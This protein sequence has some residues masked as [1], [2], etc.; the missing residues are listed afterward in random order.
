M[1]NLYK[2]VNK[3]KKRITYTRNTAQKHF[4]KHK[5][6]RN[7][8][9]KSRQLGFT[10]EEALDILDDTLFTR[11]FDGLLIAH[12]LEDAIKIFDKKIDFAWK[13]FNSELRKLWKVSADRANELKYDFGDNTFSSISVSNSGRSGTF[14][15]VHISEFAKLCN[16]YPA[17]AEEV[18]TGTIPAVPML[19]R[20]DIESTAEGEFGHFYDMFWKA[21]ERGEPTQPTEY[22]AHF[23][24]WTWDLDELA[25]L[26]EPIKDLPSEFKDYQKLHNLTDIQISY[27]YLKWISLNENWKKLQ[28]EYPT[29]PE[30]AFVSSGSKLFNADIVVLQNKYIKDGTQ[31]NNWTIYEDYKPNHRYG[32]GADVSHGKG[33]DGSTVVIIDF[34]P[35]IPK[36]VAE[37]YSNE[38]EPTTFAH[39]IKNGLVRFGTP[40][41]AVENND[42]GYTTLVTLKDIYPM[43]MIYKKEVENKEETRQTADLGWNTNG[44]TKPKMMF[45][46][47]EAL[48]EELIEIPSRVILKELRTYDENNLT[49]IKFDDEMSQ[50]WDRV[51]ALAIAWQM[52]D[53][54]KR[55]IVNNF[56][57]TKKTLR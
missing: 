10:T 55:K 44:A 2:I 40:L 34:T 20:V 33:K 18:I 21:W 42:R 46:L 54:V 48:E 47:N 49:Q 39:E 22:K 23:Y 7:L 12:T 36:V 30:E 25:L 57:K 50:H 3:S 41:I 8:I 14:N 5:W 56:N 37:Y 16:K 29:T 11:N 24:N 9:L 13:N 43:R 52:K 17:K 19:G 4:N 6:N 45:D 1:S 31:L 27:Y 26:K 38:I 32:A 53:K 51:I 15:R 28:Q 35:L